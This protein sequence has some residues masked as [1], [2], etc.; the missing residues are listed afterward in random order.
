[1]RVN[2]SFGCPYRC[3]FCSEQHHCKR[4][5]NALPAERIIE[6][7]KKLRAKVDF[8]C[9][10]FTDNNFFVSEK[11]VAD[12][13]GALINGGFNIAIGGISGRANELIRYKPS[14]WELLRDAGL[15]SV[16]IGAES[17]NDETLKFICKDI[18]VEQ[19]KQACRLCVHYGIVPVLAFVIGFPVQTYF[20]GEPEAAFH[21]EFGE[22]YDFYKTLIN[23][24]GH[25]FE[26]MLFFYTPYP[27]SPLYDVALA[28]G[29]RPPQTLEGWSEYD[30][31]RDSVPWISPKNAQGI[32]VRM[33][34]HVI[35]MLSDGYVGYYRHL[36]GGLGALARI[37]T[38]CMRRIAV[39][40]LKYNCIAF[41]L[42]MYVFRFTE[43]VFR[44]VNKQIRVIDLSE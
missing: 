18:T 28:H 31:N 30:M 29:F 21:G 13:C 17:A 2:T 37:W 42:D 26:L 22:I 38:S 41:P 32:K 4:V 6:L 7:L 3:G 15:K 24:I 20:A 8:D 27:S 40:R 16:L 43:A 11:R 23:E 44:K 39:I 5:W 36:P 1:V 14:T 34:R 25:R 35:A 12:F 33:F 10:Q 19:T 9:V